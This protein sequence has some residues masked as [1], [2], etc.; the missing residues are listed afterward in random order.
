MPAAGPAIPPVTSDASRGMVLPADI[1][2]DAGPPSLPATSNHQ[3]LF[4]A[5]VTPAGLALPNVSQYPV[6][7]VPAVSPQVQLRRSTREQKQRA[8]YNP[9]T[10]GSTNPNAVSE[11]M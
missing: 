5:R 1:M 6:A 9:A 7:S 11:D 2:S 10:G 8:C 3:V 4:A